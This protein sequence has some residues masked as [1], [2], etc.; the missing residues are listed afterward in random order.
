[1]SYENIKFHQPHMV[2][3]DGYFY[4]LDYTQR[5][6]S[7]KTSNGETSFQY[8]VDIPSSFGN[9]YVVDPV[10]CLQYDGY[11]FWSLQ[12]ITD[13]TGLVIR[14][15]T[16]TNFICLL[17][18]QFNYI[19]DSSLKYSADTFSVECY[20]TKLSNDYGDGT[21]IINIDE[22]SSF[23]I[24]FGTLLGI[25]PNKFGNRE[26]VLV[27]DTDNLDIILNTGLIH[28]YLSGDPVVIV[29]GIFIFNKYI[30]GTDDSVGTLLVI[31]PNSGEILNRQDS[32]DYQNIK[33][34][35]FKRLKN[36]LNDYEDIHTLTFVS[37]TSLKLQDTSKLK[38]FKASIIG[39]DSFNDPFL[40]LYNNDRW[41]VD[42][43]NPS[44]I[45]DCLYF[46]AAGSEHDKL[47]T[48]YYLIDDY[49]VQISGTIF[50]LNT[51]PGPEIPYC[52]HYIKPN[53]ES[54]SA[55]IYF[56]FK[57]S[58]TYYKP[59]SDADLLLYL[60]FDNSIL[61]YSGDDVNITVYGTPQFTSGFDETAS[62]A[63]ILNSYNFLVIPR[64]YTQFKLMSE[65]PFTVNEF[66]IVFWIKVPSAPYF[67]THNIFRPGVDLDTWESNHSEGPFVT[68][69][70]G[71][72]IIDRF[73]QCRFLGVTIHPGEDELSVMD[74]IYI[75]D[76]VT[77]D[78]EPIPVDTWVFIAFTADDNHLIGY[79]NG[80]FCQ[81]QQI[82]IRPDSRDHDICIGPA[83]LNFEITDDYHHD[84]IGD[85][86]LHIDEFRV[87][88]RKLTASDIRAIYEKEKDVHSEIKDTPIICLEKDG[89]I[90]SYYPL[91]SG[92]DNLS[93][94]FKLKKLDNNLNFEYKICSFGEDLADWSLMYTF[95]D[96]SHNTLSLG[97]HT[98]LT[99]VSGAYFDD[100]TFTSGYA[101]YTPNLNN[102]Y[103]TMNL[104]NIKKNQS[105]IIP[106]YAI[107]IYEDNLYRL[108]LAATYYGSD[109]TWS[110]YNYQISPIR[111]FV[112]FIT[113]DSSTGILP[114]TG[115]NT[116]V[117][118]SVTLDQYGQGV[119]NRP[120]SFSD[121]DPI[122][123][124]TSK[125][126]YTDI[127][128][129]TGSANTGYTSGTALRVVKIDASVTQLD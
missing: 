37:N 51:Y 119:I 80:D 56:G 19:N 16:I 58:T 129:N 100:F 14:C 6:M 55:E 28:T 62:S 125:T 30:S 72:T 33:A 65:D 107:D 17:T 20:S 41:I 87:Y 97:L 15:W 26:V 112:D 54:E 70:G 73:I 98:H 69:Y 108:Q 21:S 77:V 57:Y 25:G 5:L 94:K 99:V 45:N 88:K 36:I 75:T 83:N 32:V 42:L 103:G 123:F 10:T 52:N 22:F 109:I 8:P 1:M 89:F 79:I 110:T 101:Q 76:P 67:A 40:D 104:E 86:D 23:A 18:K 39:N 116:A 50:G 12:K 126:V 111:S 105:T 127:F 66:S 113:V 64:E 48:S 31:D 71:S 11:N 78:V 122:G 91:A 61:D 82:V 74:D 93:Y 90:E 84:P 120:V 34:S 60:K 59:V 95:N 81:A 115:R 2:V 38:R 24:T 44:L 3:Q 29:S 118:R 96:S 7:Q 46:S 121:D 92:I 9:N 68:F 124:I 4:L 102:Y 13:G 43:G 85:I 47:T 53:F 114:A 27:S 35:S 117:I 106:V 128:Y 49:E 63:I